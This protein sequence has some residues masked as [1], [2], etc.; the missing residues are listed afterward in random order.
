MIRSSKRSIFPWE[1]A[2][3]C[4]AGVLGTLNGLD[5]KKVSL[6]ISNTTFRGLMIVFSVTP[7][8]LDLDGWQQEVQYRQFAYLW[9]I[10]AQ[11]L[12]GVCQ[13][14]MGCSI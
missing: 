7:Q 8:S 2:R 5:K 14:I 9:F 10:V 11:H 12:I 3:G 6:E 1:L 13:T 4:V